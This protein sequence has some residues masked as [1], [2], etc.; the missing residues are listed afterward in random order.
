MFE[1]LENRTDRPGSKGCPLDFLRQ[2]SVSQILEL[3]VWA[4]II[5]REN[6]SFIEILDRN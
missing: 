1:N 2:S 3:C 5:Q 6:P 4:I